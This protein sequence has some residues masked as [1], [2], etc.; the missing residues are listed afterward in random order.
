MASLDYPAYVAQLIEEIRPEL[1][2]RRVEISGV[3]L[4]SGLRVRFDPRRIAH[5]FMNLIHNA[6]DAMT[7][8]GKITIRIHVEGDEVFTEIR[9]TGPG[10]PPEIADRLF[11]PFVT[12]GKTRGTGLGLSISKRVVQDHRGRISVVSEP[13]KGAA[14]TFVLPLG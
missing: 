8:G 12:F 9:D 2:L 3:D 7:H 1:A 13:G 4:P 14:F 11:E 5:V 10:I 6:C